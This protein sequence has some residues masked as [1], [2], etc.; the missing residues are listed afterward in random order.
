[1]I[2][3]IPYYSEDKPEFKKSLA[4]QT[5]NATIV[6]RDTKK[7]KI[8]HGKAVNDF[9]EV[10]K[11]MKPIGV[12]GITC[13]D[14]SFP[15]DFLEQ[16]SKVK[17]G[18]V[19]IPEGVTIDWRRKRI[20]HGDRVDCFSGRCFFMTYRDFIDSGKFSKMLPH[21]L[22]DYDYAIRVLKKL[23]PV[24]MDSKIRHK[25]HSKVTK[26]FSMLCPANPIFWTIFLLRHPNRYT[27]LN[28]LKAWIDAW[29][30]LW[31]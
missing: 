6:R 28:I 5:I 29:R 8:Y 10:M 27:P 11:L 18:E 31:K 22:S 26:P 23:K 15:D 2:V 13:N 20:Y 19:L 1:M 17:Q 4:R 7:D 16:G 14:I 21:Y 3:F 25:E 12:V 9:I 24:L 30:L